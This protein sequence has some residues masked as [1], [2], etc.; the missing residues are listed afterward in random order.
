MSD[1]YRCAKSLRHQFEKTWHR[2]KNPLNRSRLYRQIAWCNALVSNDKSDYYSK[3]ISDNSHDCR[4]LW[5]ELHKTLNR[6]SDATLASNESEKSLADQFVSFFSSKIKK[7]RD[8]FAPKEWIDILLPSLTKL[9]NCSLMDRCIP[10]AFKSA[11]LTPLIKK[12]NLPS[13]DLKNY[14]PVSG[15]S[16][17]SKL[18]ERVVAKQLLEHIHAH[19]LDN[20]Y[21]SAYKAGHSTET[22]LLC[23][24]MKFTYHCQE[25]KPLP[26]YC[27]TCLP[28]LTP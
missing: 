14:R 25:V 27:L 12:P 6:V 4:K 28:P 15:L 18:V 2:A 20:P 13:N 23:I 17:I 19:N 3:L 22:A 10:D 7:I 9:G 1:Y 11:V 8:N 16:F 5:R 24:K 26:W 21:Q